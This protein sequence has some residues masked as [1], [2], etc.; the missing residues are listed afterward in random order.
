MTPAPD[1]LTVAL[2]GWHSREWVNVSHMLFECILGAEGVV[3]QSQ[4][5]YFQRSNKYPAY[6]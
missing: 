3:V 2:R 4:N 1:E 6:T 5:V